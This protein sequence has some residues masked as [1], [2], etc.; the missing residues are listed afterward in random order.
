MQIGPLWASV[1]PHCT[2]PLECDAAGNPRDTRTRSGVPGVGQVRVARQVAE[3]R[4]EQ[5]RVVHHDQVGILEFDRSGITVRADEPPPSNHKMPPNSDQ[6]HTQVDTYSLESRYTVFTS[7]WGTPQPAI[8]CC[9]SPR[10]G[11]SVRGS[12]AGA[13]MV[14]HAA[15]LRVGYWL[16]LA[17]KPAIPGTVNATRPRSGV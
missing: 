14:A 10:V 1:R 11:A 15:V 7:D 17:M 9:S 8:C 16:C 3:V 2:R 5:L 13:A 4:G 6:L 12:I